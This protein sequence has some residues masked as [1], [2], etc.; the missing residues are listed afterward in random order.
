MQRHIAYA[1]EGIQVT[2][3]AFV[4][5]LVFQSLQLCGLQEWGWELMRYTNKRIVTLYYR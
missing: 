4:T 5:Y 2:V 1:P 3:T